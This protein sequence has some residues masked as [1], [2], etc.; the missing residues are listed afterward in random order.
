MSTALV[1]SSTPTTPATPPTRAERR[2]RETLVLG[3]MLFVFTWT[4]EVLA[5]PHYSDFVVFYTMGHVAAA[6]DFIALTSDAALQAWQRDLLPASVS[7][8][9]PSVYP[10]QIALLMRPFAALPYWPGHGVLVA[11]SVAT[12]VFTTGRM[13]AT[14][15]RLARW[16][17]QVAVLTA[18][19]P[20]VWALVIMGQISALA[21]AA[22]WAAWLALH[23][24]RR[25]LA[26]AALGVLAY[27][28]P[29]FVVAAAVVL[30]AG[31]WA[32]VM[33]AVAAAAT[34]YVVAIPFVGIGVVTDYLLRLLQLAAAPDRLAEKFLMQHSSR[35]F[36]T[37]LLPAA[38]A[39]A[40]YV[41]TGAATV[42]GS[43]W[44]WRRLPDPLHRVAIL[45]TAIVLA[46]PHLFAYDLVLLF[47][48]AVASAELVL[49]GRGHRTLTW[50]MVAGCAAPM[51]SLP[52]AL[53]NVQASTPVLAAWL[54]EFV[55][56][57]VRAR[58]DEAKAAA[59]PPP[60]LAT[61]T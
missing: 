12:C 11:L 25:W 39:N 28:A 57:A 37:A 17:R 21:L 14:L 50:L 41:V 49:A 61:S 38:V 29:L 33:A 6:G 19:S 30:L 55:R 16:P 51:W 9:Y 46:S 20:L 15:P 18:A 56:L 1:P 34:Q 45:G 31:E 48:L 22:L 2:A 54:V 32:M 10:P 52:V 59:G 24:E 8:P 36:W 47:P 23:A 7:T 26:G 60:L 42:L 27:K 13:A 3:S 44:A 58:A 4:I 53:L 35:V 5:G 43:A 40:A